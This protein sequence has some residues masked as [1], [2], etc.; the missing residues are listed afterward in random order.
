MG[1]GECCEYAATVLATGECERWG[2]NE[3]S[4]GAPLW[5]GEVAAREASGR[6]LY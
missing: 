5:R 6:P 4:R 3:G 2:E 1:V